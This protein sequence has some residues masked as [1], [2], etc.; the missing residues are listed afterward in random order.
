M[1]AW[2]RPPRTPLTRATFAVPESAADTPPKAANPNR[3]ALRSA[4]QPTAIQRVPAAR[5]VGGSFGGLGKG[6]GSG[7]SRSG[8]TGL[9]SRTLVPLAAASRTGEGYGLSNGGARHGMT[10]QSTPLPLLGVLAGF[11]RFSV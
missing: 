10:R 2:N 6:S 3:M 9:A 11:R 1:T 8:M 4:Q 5:T 7:S